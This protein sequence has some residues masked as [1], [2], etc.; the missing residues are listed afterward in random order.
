MVT[1]DDKDR[2]IIAERVTRFNTLPGPR[3]GDYIDF[4]DGTTRR[5][6]YVW[7]DGD[8]QTTDGGSFH[9]SGGGCDF[10]GSLYRSVPPRSVVPTG[11]T[12]SG[13][14]WIFHHGHTEAHNGVTGV[15]DF[16]VYRCSQPAP[17]S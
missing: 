7:E 11:E 3:V 5:I 8:I 13:M 9:F 1:L 12:R 10:S 2:E 6:A 15:I 14:V 16:R 4:A 17:R